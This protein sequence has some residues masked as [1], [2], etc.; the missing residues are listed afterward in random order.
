M[1]YS[2]G[3]DRVS[4]G[5]HFPYPIKLEYDQTTELIHLTPLIIPEDF[6][7]EYQEGELWLVLEIGGPRLNKNGKSRKSR[8]ELHPTEGGNFYLLGN[9]NRYR[10]VINNFTIGQ[11]YE[12]TKP[13]LRNEHIQTPR[14]SGTNRHKTPFISYRG[15]YRSGGDIQNLRR[16]PNYA[17]SNVIRILDTGEIF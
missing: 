4:I 11:S 15:S 3:S 12:F 9:N 1:N 6:S 5:N 17:S 14:I 8:S 10:F 7:S 2:L 16:L 13:L